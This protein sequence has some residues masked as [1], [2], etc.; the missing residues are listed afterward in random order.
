MYTD[1]PRSKELLAN[2]KWV[3]DF[4]PDAV[5]GGADRHILLEQISGDRAL[6]T[7]WSRKR[8]CLQRYI[9]AIGSIGTAMLIDSDDLLQR[10]NNNVAFKDV[11]LRLAR[12]RGNYVT[13]HAVR[14]IVD[15][16]IEGPGKINI[17]T[18]HG[19][20]QEFSRQTILPETL[21][22]IRQADFLQMGRRA[23]GFSKLSSDKCERHI[24]LRVL[25]G[26]EG[27]LEL[28]SA[29]PN[30]R[31]GV[32]YLRQIAPADINQHV[33][34]PL[35]F[36]LF[37]RFIRHITDVGQTIEIRVDNLE[38]PMYVQFVGD[39]GIVTTPVDT[40]P[41]RVR[42]LKASIYPFHGHPTVEAEVCAVRVVDATELHQAIDCQ[43]PKKSATR[44]DLRVEQA[45]SNLEISKVGDSGKAESSLISNSISHLDVLES[46]WPT[47]SANYT[48]LL[49]SAETLRRIISWER[50][51]RFMVEAPEDNDDEFFGFEDESELPDDL[52]NTSNYIK[53]EV[54]RIPTG[55]FIVR[56][57]P[58]IYPSAQISVNAIDASLV[59]EDEE[60]E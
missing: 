5:L 10:C 6:L 58:E 57:T 36:C 25:P 19:L 49:A 13:V 27:H 17:P 53:V 52:G 16:Q 23:N 18:Y 54:L 22:V 37:G 35:E 60:E 55:M 38:H 28:Y 47:I 31:L 15:D 21:A 12:G 1:I 3:T 4:D 32:S 59:E 51:S 46:E 41:E 26:E 44:L 34:E 8:T 50:G 30:G 9:P 40:D 39:E 42:Y 7:G 20:V 45:G 48:Y 56:M 29:E 43:R 24:M 11:A 2:A 14:R 33:E